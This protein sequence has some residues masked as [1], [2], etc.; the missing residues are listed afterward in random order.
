LKALIFK[1]TLTK[2]NVKHRLAFMCSAKITT[3]Q[4]TDKKNFWKMY[5]KRNNLFELVCFQEIACVWGLVSEIL[6][7]NII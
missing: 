7:G 1:N 3:K 4:Q 5:Y 2:L 6:T